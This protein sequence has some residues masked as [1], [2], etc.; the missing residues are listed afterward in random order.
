MWI[1]YFRPIYV[2]TNAE[3]RAAA[4]KKFFSQILKIDKVEI[5]K[6]LTKK[7][8]IAKLEEIRKEAI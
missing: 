3:T 8:I 7:E 2:Y 4:A 1:E 5:L 6:N